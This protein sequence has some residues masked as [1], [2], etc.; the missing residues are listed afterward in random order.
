MI[1]EIDSPTV[2]FENTA[3]TAKIFHHPLER[4]YEI[5]LIGKVDQKDYQEAF[6]TYLELSEAQGYQIALFNNSQL[7]EDTMQS[8]AWFIAN[9]LPKSMGRIR[10]IHYRAAVVSPINRFQ[11]MITEMVAKGARALGKPMTVE[12]FD[13]TSEALQWLASEPN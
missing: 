9:Y 2:V 8:R 12:F 5:A 4:T 3:G 10:S 13:S 7:Q 1:L 6:L 11:R